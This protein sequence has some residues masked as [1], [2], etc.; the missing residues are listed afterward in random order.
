M[1]LKVVSDYDVP[2]LAGYNKSGDVI[3]VDRRVPK[4]IVVSGKAVDPLRYLLVHE[5]TEQHLEDMLGLDYLTAHHIATAAERAAV[6]ADK[7]N[8]THYSDVISAL[9]KTTENTFSFL[10]PDLDLEPYVQ[11]ADPK[12][13]SRIHELMGDSNDGSD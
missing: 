11:T 2:Y 10:P 6:E 1:S 8:W 3:Y 12:M 13:L 4:T 9:V 7:L 5:L